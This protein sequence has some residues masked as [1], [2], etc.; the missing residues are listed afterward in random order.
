[1]TY[2]N[3]SYNGGECYSTSVIANASID[4]I[5][6]LSHVPPAQR[7]P[8]FAYIAVKAPHIQDGPGW[9][10]A[11]EAPWYQHTF[12][13]VRAPRTPN[14]NMS[15]AEHHW[16]VRQQPPLTEEQAARSDALYRARWQALL[17]VDDMVEGVVDAVEQAG[18][19]AQTFFIFT[20][21][22]G[23]RF[24]QMRMPQ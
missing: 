6:E 16:L 9:P 4:W 12:P 8:F 18:M 1:M 15:C 19:L 14:W 24:G 5:N 20:S 22:H 21:D 7:K 13:G 2:N 17:S 23:Y 10:V 3:C 11:L